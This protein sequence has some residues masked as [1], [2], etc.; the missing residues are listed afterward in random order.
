MLEL[1]LARCPNVKKIRELAEEYGGEKP[2]L[3]LR[4][5]GCILCGLCVRPARKS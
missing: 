1:L 5:Q 3:T 2:T 4:D